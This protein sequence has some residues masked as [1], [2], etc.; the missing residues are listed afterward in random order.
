MDKITKNY[1][2]KHLLKSSCTYLPGIWLNVFNSGL[3]LLLFRASLVDVYQNV[4][5]EKLQKQKDL[6]LPLSDSGQKH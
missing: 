3:I 4:K 6:L 2:S 1:L 5:K